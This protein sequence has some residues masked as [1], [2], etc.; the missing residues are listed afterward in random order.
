MIWKGND[1]KTTKE[2]TSIFSVNEELHING[3]SMI[4]KRKRQTFNRSKI[5]N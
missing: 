4:L 2:K 5:S 1:K 3:V